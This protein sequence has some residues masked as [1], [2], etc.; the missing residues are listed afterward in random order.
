MC[1]SFELMQ[2]SAFTE[3]S[4]SSI[5]KGTVTHRVPCLRTVGFLRLVPWRVARIL[6]AGAFF[7]SR[8][9]FFPVKTAACKDEVQTLD[10]TVP[11]PSRSTVRYWGLAPDR[12]LYEVYIRTNNYASWLD[13]EKFLWYFMSSSGELFHRIWPKKGRILGWNSRRKAL[14]KN[15]FSKMWPS[16]RHKDWISRNLKFQAW[17]NSPMSSSGMA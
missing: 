4:W 16:G 1:M 5:P 11:S 12:S 9:H 13:D 17:R 7:R 10:W 6:W 15:T 3:F 2:D 8:S 14:P